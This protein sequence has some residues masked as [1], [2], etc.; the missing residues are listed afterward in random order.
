MFNQDGRNLHV[1]APITKDK[2]V[3]FLTGERGFV[4]PHGENGAHSHDVFLE[5]LLHEFLDIRHIGHPELIVPPIQNFMCGDK[6][7]VCHFLVCE[8]EGVQKDSAVNRI[9]FMPKE[10]F[11]PHIFNEDFRELVKILWYERRLQ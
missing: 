3:I 4:L 7:F 2:K 11:V 9:R 6:R 10:T 1:F 8:F 5:S